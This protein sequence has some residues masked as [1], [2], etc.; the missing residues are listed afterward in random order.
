MKQ[1]NPL[2]KG[3]QGTIIIPSDKS[4]SHR[5]VMFGALTCA[6][7]K[8]TN[9]SKGADCHS[10]LGI[11]KELGCDINFETDQNLTVCNKQGFQKPSKTLD[12]GNSGTT[13]RMMTGILAG[14]NFDSIITGDQSLC[15]RPMTRVIKPLELMG[16][17]I[18][19]NEG[20]APL[21]IKGT[22]L[23]AISYDSPI[24]SAQVK[25]C[26]LLAGLFADGITTVTE[27]YKSRDHSERL[28]KYLNANIDIDGNTVSIRKSILEPKPISVCGD[29]SSAAFFMA[30]AAIVP[31]SGIIIENVGLNQTRTGIIDVLKEM[32]ANLEI[33]NFRSECG[34]EVGDI[35]IS[36]SELK[37]TTI[38]GS[39]I[40]RL[41]DELPIIAVLA[42]QAD[43]ITTVKDAQD[44]RNKE[45]DRIKTIVT[46]LK[47]L[48]AN[49]EET[50][51]GFVIEGKTDL[52]G[53][54]QMECYHDHR[55]AMS[56]YVAG[57]ICQ[58]P[59]CINEF[60]W[61]NTSFPEFEEL[62][63]KIE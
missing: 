13:I 62:M 42:T 11:L 51:D 31:N 12:A 8:I 35:K 36:Y 57:L 19:S 60:E 53:D 17:R 33:L 37:G 21:T 54:V 39:I 48:G 30:A 26:V 45:S 27:P 4:L 14:Q 10:T 15:K 7:V 47:K 38:E 55:L 25:S 16:A 34:E 40:P 9:F 1:V 52:N 61:V 22:P 18:T 46:E 5:A 29:I 2:K 6:E 58:K 41:I 23:N 24:A 44:L 63:Q 49:I 56:A 43:G 3:L 59:I 32:G 20:K 50:P 28:L